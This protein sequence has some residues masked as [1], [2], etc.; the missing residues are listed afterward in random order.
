M[1]FTSR[2]FVSL[3]ADSN[4]SSGPLIEPSS[5]H[6]VFNNKDVATLS[7]SRI[8]DPQV[9]HY[10]NNDPLANH[11]TQISP[12]KIAERVSQ[13]YEKS[14]GL[15]LAPKSTKYD[16]IIVGGGHNGLVSASYLAKRGLSVL[17]LERRHII[18]GAAVTEEIIPGFKFSRASYLAGLLRPVI[19]EELEL[20]KYGMEFL[21]RDPSSFTPTKVIHFLCH[22]TNRDKKDGPHN[23]KYLVLGK[24]E[25]KNA[26]S[27][28]QFSKRD[29]EAWPEYLGFLSK[30]REL[31][32]PLL[33]EPPPIPFYG[34]SMQRRRTWTQIYNLLKV[35]YKN[36]EVC[37]LVRLHFMVL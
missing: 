21:P 18:G 22:E 1:G 36:R 16:V 10:T 8:P 26:A 19:I 3:A 29:A 33:D 11:Q 20:H 37:I 30:V 31:V 28:A 12:E 4:I 23:G 15:F 6:F 7:P 27:I 5:N 25:I 17:V 13:K 34:N 32:D 2:W 14:P 35:G 9:Y 24:D